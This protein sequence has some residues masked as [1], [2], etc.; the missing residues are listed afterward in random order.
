MVRRVKEQPQEFQGRFDRY[1]WWELH[2][3]SRVYGHAATF[4]KGGELALHLALVRPVT[5]GTLKGLRRDSRFMEQYCRQ[6]GL[7]RVVGVADEDNE[8]FHKFCVL[9]GFTPPRRIQV[10]YKEIH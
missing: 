8:L 1:D 2:D 7:S 9:M 4:A 6:H 5:P 3:G 10:A